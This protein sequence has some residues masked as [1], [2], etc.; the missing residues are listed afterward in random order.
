VLPPR[1]SSATTCRLTARRK[2][3][4]LGSAPLALR[5]WDTILV[6]YGAV[7]DLGDYCGSALSFTRFDSL[8]LIHHPGDRT[9]P[10]SPSCIFLRTL[11]YPQTVLRAL[12]PSIHPSPTTAVKSP[13]HNPKAITDWRQPTQHHRGLRTRSTTNHQPPTQPSTGPPPLWHWRT[14][15]PALLP[16]AL[17]SSA[18]VFA[19]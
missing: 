6:L 3:T 10:A 11:L 4:F 13:T 15:L 18:A 14:R 12:H 16:F 7:L 8:T 17:P 1:L 5:I 9:F 19:V 2:T